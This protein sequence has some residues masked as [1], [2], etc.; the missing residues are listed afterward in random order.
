MPVSNG[1][2]SSSSDTFVDRKDAGQRLAKAIAD[3]GIRD[4]LLV[5]GL[6][7]GGVPVAY[8]VARQ[9]KAPL[10]VWLVRKLG[11]PGH[12]ELAMGALAS[13]GARVMNDDVLRSM[14]LSQ[15]DIERVASREL[16]EL[17]RREREYRGDRAF[18]V[19]EGKTVIVVDDGLATGAS[20]RAALRAL[21]SQNPGRVVVAVPVGAP[22]VCRTLSSEA[23]DVVC[24]M[25]P[26]F[27]N[28]VGNWY[29]NFAQTTDREVRDLLELSRT[30]E[31][32]TS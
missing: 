22:E 32:G 2:R 27:F 5:L 4:H 16:K 13:G 31:E 21:Y 14:R 8:E 1:S 18:P 19:I 11:V 26:K 28:A 29:L 10:D 30:E 23:D 7:R 3:R 20:M 15:E 12:E 24:L 17:Q 9:L 6:P 25:Q